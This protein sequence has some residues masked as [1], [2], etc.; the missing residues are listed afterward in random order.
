MAYDTTFTLADGG[1]T[2]Q[3]L[4]R[5]GKLKVMHRADIAEVKIPGTDF[6]ILQHMG[7]SN[8]KYQIT[9]KVWN[10]N[11]INDVGGAYTEPREVVNKIREWYKQ[12]T[13]LSFIC[14]YITNTIETVEEIVLVTMLAIEEIPGAGQMSPRSDPTTVESGHTAGYDLK[15]EMTVFKQLDIVI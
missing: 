6:S 9:F 15:M 13:T 2:L 10:I 7:S 8:D 3:F 14:D 11:L 12:G 5:P 4:A 1:T